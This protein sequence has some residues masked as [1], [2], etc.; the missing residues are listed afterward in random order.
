MKLQTPNFV[1]CFIHNLSNYDAHFIVTE[2][3]NDVNEINVIP[4]REEKFISFSKHIN[5][6]FH[7]RFIDTFRFMASSLAT[8]AS[9]LETSDFRKFRETGKMFTV[10]DLPLI[11]R[12]D[13][14]V[15]VYR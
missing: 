1:S 12:K 10:E 2:L 9:N 6:K 14:P 7:I 4:N 8:S 5:N 11:T 15:R 13:I 3:G